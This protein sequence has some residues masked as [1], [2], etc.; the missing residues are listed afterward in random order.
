M[1]TGKPDEVGEVGQEA[2]GAL[3]LDRPEGGLLGRLVGVALAV[4]Y[5]WASGSLT[6]RLVEDYGWIKDEAEFA[7]AFFTF[8]CLTP[9]FFLLSKFFEKSSSFLIITRGT[10]NFTPTNQSFHIGGETT[11]RAKPTSLFNR[12][13]Y[14][15]LVVGLGMGAFCIDF[16]IVQ[17][18]LLLLLLGVLVA[19]LYL[20][21]SNFPVLFKADDQIIAL[22]SNSLEWKDV[23]T[24]K[25]EHIIGPFGNFSVVKL[26]FIGEDGRRIGRI[27]LPG[28]KV[29]VLTERELLVF[30]ARV[31]GQRVLPVAP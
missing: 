24:V 26:T 27:S 28:D 13:M 12:M 23:Q 14:S 16:W 15:L 5:G 31:L 30:F 6:S 1:E 19:P 17:I 4:C 11:L 3:I 18:W 7:S 2:I 21:V 20:V 10:E 22:R 29:T 8:L 9:A 25:A